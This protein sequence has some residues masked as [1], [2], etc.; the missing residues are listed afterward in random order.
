M[1]QLHQG[2]ECVLEGDLLHVGADGARPH[3]LQLGE[4]GRDVVAHGTLGDHH[5]SLRP[6]VGDA[7]GLVDPFTGHG[8]Q[9]ADLQL[10]ALEQFHFDSVL[11]PYNYPMMQNPTY[12]AGFEKLYQECQARDVAVQTIKSLAV[13]PWGDKSQTRACWYEPF[14]DQADIDRAVNF[15]LSKEETEG[16]KTFTKENDLT[17]YMSLLSVFSI[18]LSKLSGQDDIVVGAPI[19]GRNHADLENIVGMFINTLSIRNKVKGEEIC[20]LFPLIRLQ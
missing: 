17:L 20:L 11:L 8:I 10:H 1:L 4:L 9:I 7:A 6:L 13:G 3:E 16:I 15:V 12:A 18:L 2:G 5:H 14:E 19:A